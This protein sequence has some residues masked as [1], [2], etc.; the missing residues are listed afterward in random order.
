M[1]KQPILDRR[2]ASHFS[3]LRPLR[4]VGYGLLALAI[5]DWV[6]LLIPL[7]LMNPVWELQTLGELVE[8]V[9]VLLVGA[10]LVFLGDRE[11]IEGIE[12]WVLKGLSWCMLLLAIAYFLM[13]P[14]GL[15]NTSQLDRQTRQRIDAQ[16]VE[17]RTLA[18]QARSSLAQVQ[19]SGDL[20]IL[21]RHLS[22]AGIALPSGDAPDLETLKTHVQ[23]ELAVM[24]Q[25]VNHQARQNLNDERFEL[26]K[27]SLKWNLGAL[28]SAMLFMILWR[29]SAWVRRDG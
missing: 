2:A 14:W 15:F 25:Q 9:P 5:F 26:F 8:K 4:W 6:E 3:A 21:V 18:E 13:I 16:V 20:Q 29:G 7:Q 11:E 1:T 24:E 23:Q 10:A 19:T 12:K 17:A 22:Q 27:K 28:V